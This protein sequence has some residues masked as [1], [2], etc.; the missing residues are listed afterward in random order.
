MMIPKWVFPSVSILLNC[1]S[2][3]V[4]LCHG[5]IKRAVYWGAAAVLTTT[6]T[7]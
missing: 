5:D 4:C 2:A 3:I 7:I 6:V 1:G